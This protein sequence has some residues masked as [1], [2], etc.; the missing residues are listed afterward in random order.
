MTNPFEWNVNWQ[1]LTTLITGV[2]AVAGAAWVANKQNGLRRNE[3]RIALLKERRDVIERFRVLATE[4]QIGARMSRDGEQKLWTLV[5]DTRLLFEESVYSAAN[6]LFDS[7][8][9][10][11]MYE[12]HA[13]MYER[14]GDEQKRM[15]SIER[16]AE[17]TEKISVK[18]PE[19]MQLLVS[20]AQVG[21]I[22]K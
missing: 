2:A 15:T 13:S 7:I 17:E 16:E 1:A 9:R 22:F 6:E 19:L 21:S 12:R 14:S 18:I 20:A 8:S 4:W 3:A 11:N 10:Q 5:Q